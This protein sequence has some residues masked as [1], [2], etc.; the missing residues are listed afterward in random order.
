MLSELLCLC[1]LGCCVGSCQCSS[2]RG[3][4]ILYVMAEIR[5]LYPSHRV[6][7]LTFYLGLRAFGIWGPLFDSSGICYLHLWDLMVLNSFNH[8]RCSQTLV[9]EDRKVATLLFKIP[10]GSR[11][12]SI[13][14]W[15]CMVLHSVTCHYSWVLHV[16]RAKSCNLRSEESLYFCNLCRP[17]HPTLQRE[18]TIS[19]KTWLIPFTWV[20]LLLFI[21]SSPCLACNYPENFFSYPNW[22]TKWEMKVE[23]SWFARLGWFHSSQ[24]YP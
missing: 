15:S 21:T 17:F 16:K 14:L 4:Y 22:H 8:R 9:R 24:V 20:T 2:V 11:I 18:S 23:S 10:K 7:A 5:W 6:C 19:L 12:W 13:L 3:C 1:S